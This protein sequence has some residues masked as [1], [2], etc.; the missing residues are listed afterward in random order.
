MRVLRSK[1]L[2]AAAGLA[3]LAA[4]HQSSPTAPTSNNPLGLTLAYPPGWNALPSMGPT[5]IVVSNT[6]VF[7]EMPTP[8]ALAT[9]G[10]FQLQLMSN[11]NPSSLPIDQWFNQ[12]FSNDFSNPVLSRTSVTVGGKPAVRISVVELVETAYLYVASSTNVIEV[13]FDLAPSTFT[14]QYEMLLSSIKFTQ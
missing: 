2:V 9:Q 1:S 7:D 3:A 8:S 5:T 10:V 4:C 14:Q 12:Y 13:S 11:V 6:S